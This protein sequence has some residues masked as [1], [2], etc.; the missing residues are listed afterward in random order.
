MHGFLHYWAQNTP[1]FW[2]TGLLFLLFLLTRKLGGVTKCYPLTDDGSVLFPMLYGYYR[3]ETRRWLVY[4]CFSTFWTSNT[5]FSNYSP[6]EIHENAF[7]WT[8]IAI[9]S[10]LLHDNSCYDLNTNCH[11]I[12]I[13]LVAVM[14]FLEHKLPLIHDY[15]MIIH[16]IIWKRIAINCH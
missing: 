15:Y 13:N 6:P 14:L 1:L 16:V 10:W 5:L 3:R 12:A 8:Q 7:I 2:G 11:L 4:E 9:N